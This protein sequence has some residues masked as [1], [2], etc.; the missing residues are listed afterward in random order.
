MMTLSVFTPLARGPSVETTARIFPWKSP[1]PSTC[2][3]SE[4]PSKD[5]TGYSL[6]RLTWRRPL[7]VGSKSEPIGTPRA[8]ASLPRV[9][10]DGVSR[11]D[12]IW[13][14][15]DGVRPAFSASCRCWRPRS[16]LS[17]LMR[18][19][20]AVIYPQPALRQVDRSE[21]HTSELQS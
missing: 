8:P 9:G 5:T 14:T 16:P 11:P 1:A 6:L 15:M 20:R 17:A 19:P 10:R 4:V 3:F 12:S 7:G 2:H 13:E 21:E 18:A